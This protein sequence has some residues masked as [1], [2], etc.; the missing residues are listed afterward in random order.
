MNL[1]GERE[2]TIVWSISGLVRYVMLYVPNSPHSV[3]WSI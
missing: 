3:M 2:V 1:H